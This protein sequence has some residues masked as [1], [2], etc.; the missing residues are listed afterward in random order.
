MNI[1][2]KRLTTRQFAR[3]KSRLCRSDTSATQGGFVYDEVQECNR[4]ALYT[5][6]QVPFY[7]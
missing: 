2:Q 6:C 7:T 4:H 3:T 1:D 5:L